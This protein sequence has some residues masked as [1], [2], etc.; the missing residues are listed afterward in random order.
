MAWISDIHFTYF[1]LLPRKLLKVLLTKPQA[2]KV[3]EA[4]LWPV[5]Y[6]W[7]I[8]SQPKTRYCYVF[9]NFLR[10]MIIL[11]KELFP[12]IFYSVKSFWRAKVMKTFSKT[13]FYF[14]FTW[15]LTH[16]LILHFYSYTFNAFKPFRW[17]FFPFEIIQDWHFSPHS[18]SQFTMIKHM[19]TAKNFRMPFL[20][21]MQNIWKFSENKHSKFLRF[22]CPC[23]KR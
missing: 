8:V 7:W 1:D 16:S 18:F 19:I 20:N 17:S 22:K 5:H 12:P 2:E 9:E 15:S 14:K 6:L 23:S 21:T 4:P 13:N 10:F 11:Y 3:R